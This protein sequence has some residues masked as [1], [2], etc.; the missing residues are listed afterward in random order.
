[1][2]HKRILKWEIIGF[3]I[4]SL[5]GSA[6]HFCYEW[7]GYFK[8]LALFCAVNESVWEHVKMGFWPAAFYAIAEYFAFGKNKKNFIAAKTAA[9]YMLP[10]IIITV[11][12]LLE[13]IL[14]KHAVWID[15]T[16]FIAAILISQWFSYKIIISYRDYSRYRGLSYILLLLIVI[17]FSLFTF[18]PP[19]LELFRDPPT[20][21]Y[22]ILPAKKQ[23]LYVLHYT[24]YI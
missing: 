5:V 21:G 8:P 19:H 13:A 6:F 18:F 22:G 16:L 11:Y 10:I 3:F 23:H 24:I 9:L 20:G 1:M 4:I 15:I 12:Y 14:G 7:S 17:A 2:N